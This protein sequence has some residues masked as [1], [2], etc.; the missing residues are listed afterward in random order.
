MTQYVSFYLFLFIYNFWFAYFSDNGP[1]KN[2]NKI[3]LNLGISN[4]YLLQQ[5]NGNEN[6]NAFQFLMLSSLH[7]SNSIYNPFLNSNSLKFFQESDSNENKNSFHL[8]DSNSTYNSFLNSN[9]S[10]LNSVKNYSRVD[11][12]SSS[13]SPIDAFAPIDTLNRYI[14]IS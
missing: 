2:S 11:V 3:Q 12:S 5:L 8:L 9:N 6:R 14:N 7:A 1:K 13:I 4:N 10:L